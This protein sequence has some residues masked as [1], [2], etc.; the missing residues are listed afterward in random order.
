MDERYLFNIS[1]DDMIS[2]MLDCI[3]N[4]T[5]YYTY[6]WYHEDKGYIEIVECDLLSGKIVMTDGDFSY[7]D[8][9]MEESNIYREAI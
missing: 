9:E 6:Y 8:W 3:R 1:L 2:E 4:G 5:C 7:F